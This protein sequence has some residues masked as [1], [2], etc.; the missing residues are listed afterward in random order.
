MAPAC[1]RPASLE[2]MLHVPSFLQL[3]AVLDIRC[4]LKSPLIKPVIVLYVDLGLIT[5]YPRRPTES[6][7]V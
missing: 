7:W 2:T 4:D 1:A 5:I 3:S 6:A